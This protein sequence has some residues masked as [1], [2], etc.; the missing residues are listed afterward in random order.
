MNPY[1]IVASDLDGTLLNNQAEISRENLDAISRIAERGGE[2]VVAT[3]RTY[4]EIPE[5][6][7]N[8]PAIRYMIYSNGAVILD[9]KTGE[10]VYTCI[11]NSLVCRI[12]DILTEYKVHISIRHQGDCCVDENYQEEEHYQ[13]FRVDRCHVDVVAKCGVFIHDFDGYMR[14]ADN[15][16]VV[17]IFFH[18]PAEKEACRAKLQDLGGLYLAEAS[19]SNFEIVNAK[20]G[21]GSALLAL[22]ERIGVPREKTMAL[23]DSG[24]DLT[25]IRT[26]G[27]GLA[28]RNAQK[29]LLDEADGVICSNEEH[30]AKYVLETYFG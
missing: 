14:A 13:F 25:M 1:T 30:V 29:I 16:E 24:N 28:T 15:V 8:H 9:K 22:A 19:P 26:A 6:V 2:F 7:R 21:K 17:S 3:G 12:A 27:L 18:D 5:I 4:A 11:P 20:A 23:G 10:K